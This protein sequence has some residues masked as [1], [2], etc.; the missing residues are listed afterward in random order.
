MSIGYNYCADFGVQGE[1][2][3]EELTKEPEPEPEPAAE[4]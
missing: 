1:A 4:E 3:L 2:R